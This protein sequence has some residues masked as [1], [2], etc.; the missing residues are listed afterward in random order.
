MRPICWDPTTD[1]PRCLGYVPVVSDRELKKNIREA[2]LDEVLSRLRKLPISTWS[3]RSEPGTVRHLGPMAQDFHAVFSLGSEERS[4]NPV[5][6]HGVA[7]AAIK[8][9]DRLVQAQRR[10]IESLE[11][12]NRELGRLIRALEVH[13]GSRRGGDRLDDSP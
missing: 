12:A 10:R 8:G 7:M 2:D 13:R 6:G 5:D 1:A 3:Y 4:Y 9:L 11:H